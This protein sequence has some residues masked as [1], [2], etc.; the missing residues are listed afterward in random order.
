[1]TEAEFLNY[2]NGPD[3]Q[4]VWLNM[5]CIMTIF[6]AAIAYP[7]SKNDLWPWA[8]SDAFCMS[9]LVI[10]LFQIGL[11]IAVLCSWLKDLIITIIWWKSI[12]FFIYILVIWVGTV[13]NFKLG[14]PICGG[15][16]WYEDEWKKISAIICP[17]EVVFSL[18]IM[19]LFA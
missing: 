13:K 11:S 7:I 4:I 8:C 6:I 1:M 17:I 15:Y 18:L 2:L 5:L 9:V 3:G 12:I 16:P 14:N 19:F 10:L